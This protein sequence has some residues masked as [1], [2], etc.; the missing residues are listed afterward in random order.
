MGADS[1]LLRHRDAPAE[2]SNMRAAAF[3]NERMAAPLINA[4][5]LALEAP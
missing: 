5:R 1:Y 2:P 4:F 3:V